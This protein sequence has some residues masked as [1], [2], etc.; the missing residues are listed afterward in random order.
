MTKRLGSMAKAASP[1][2]A[3]VCG[4]RE[5]KAAERR[6]KEEEDDGAPDG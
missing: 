5:G 6:A 4:V 1:S 3:M 2:A